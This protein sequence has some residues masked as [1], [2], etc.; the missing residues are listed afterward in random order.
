MS[1]VTAV[2]IL[3]HRRPRNRSVSLSQFLTQSRHSSLPQPQPIIQQHAHIPQQRCHPANQPNQQR[4]SARTG[5]CLTACCPA[6]V[7][8]RWLP[9]PLPR[10][11]ARRSPA[12]AHGLPDCCQSWRTPITSCCVLASCLAS[13]PGLPDCWW[14][15]P[16]TSG[17]RAV[18]AQQLLHSCLG[19]ASAVHASHQRLARTG[20]C[21]PAAGAHGL[22]DCCQDLVVDAE[23]N[24]LALAA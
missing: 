18:A 23:V 14:R 9:A 16:V 12:C 10:L 17:W 15:T 24:V 7:T 3:L 13:A 2:V 22:P 19:T 1:F 5:C 11:N 6:A 21:S 8:A 20:C 4:W